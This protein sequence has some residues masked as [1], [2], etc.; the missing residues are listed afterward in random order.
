MI[1][2]IKINLLKVTMVIAICF[3]VHVLVALI[4]S[5]I[6]NNFILNTRLANFTIYD[7][8]ADFSIVLAYILVSALL[9]FDK[10][11]GNALVV[12]TV[13][14]FAFLTVKVF[15]IDIIAHYVRFYL[16]TQQNGIYSFEIFKDRLASNWDSLLFEFSNLGQFLSFI[17]WV[18]IALLGVCYLSL[19]A[20]NKLKHKLKVSPVFGLLL[21][22]GFSSCGDNIQREKDKYPEI[23]VF[24]RFANDAL[25]Y[26]KLDVATVSFKDNQ[27]AKVD[28]HSLVIHTQDYFFYAVADSSLFLITGYREALKP[29]MEY[30]AKNFVTLTRLRNKKIEKLVWTD[31]CDND[32]PIYN[33]GKTLIV[34]SRVFEAIAPRLTFTKVDKTDDDLVNKSI[35]AYTWNFDKK[36]ISE[37][38]KPYD[39][40][41]VKEFDRVTIGSDGNFSGGLNNGI[42]Y[43]YKAVSMIY[44]E[45]NLGGKV[46]KT[47]INFD[48][49]KVPLLIKIKDK[50]YSVSYS[51][52][53]KL[54]RTVHHY[55]IGVIES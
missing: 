8:Y 20:K 15:V 54:R 40:T 22:L 14:F 32:L 34:G 2:S 44:Y 18:F 25:T 6:V 41:F 31:T 53:L 36:L 50:V 55:E 39:S 42:N 28:G 5:L 52:D 26:K 43:T 27:T 49:Q 51:F 45:F 35:M 47:K 37:D 4:S 29:G 3:A 33:D 46:G 1:R 17:V 21:I 48:E 9:I 10:I 12:T 30:P 19:W 16:K 13:S 7:G 11:Q 24:P 38:Y 23:P